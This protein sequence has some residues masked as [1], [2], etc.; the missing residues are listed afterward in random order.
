MSK[1]FLLTP[2]ILIMFISGC[3][4]PGTNIVIPFLPN[5][6]GPTTVEYENDILIIKNLQ[7]SPSTVVKSQQPF[8]IYADIENLDR[9]EKGPLPPSGSDDKIYVRLFD[10]CTNLMDE[11]KVKCPD[12]NEKVGDECEIEKIYP[13]EVKTITWTLTPKDLDLEQSCELRLKV[14]Y[15][16][17]TDA[18]THI[19]FINDAELQNRI[20]R[21]ESYQVAGSETRGEGPVKPYLRVESQ[22]PIS[23]ASQGQISLQVRNV[24]AGFV[25]GNKISS[26]VVVVETDDKLDI[27]RI[28]DDGVAREECKLTGDRLNLVNKETSPVFCFATR[29][30]INVLQTFPITTS[31]EYGYEF[32]DSIMVR[33][34]PKESAL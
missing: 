27:K 17:S 16:Y 8:L 7:I 13:K 3:T 23:D 24:G 28:D 2:L 6:W 34:L 1:Y 18:I 33:I 21:G 20:R 19:S 12:E 26:E 30:E 31:I 5:L 4:I 22:Q 11:V 32:R 15:N 29:P 9:P 10:Y 14:M 25:P